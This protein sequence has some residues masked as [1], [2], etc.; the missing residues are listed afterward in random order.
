MCIRDRLTG[1][2]FKAT[3][4]T[5]RE[6]FHSYW[7]MDGK[8]KYTLKKNIYDL[9]LSEGLF[10]TGD[11]TIDS[12][13]MIGNYQCVVELEGQKFVSSRALFSDLNS[14]FSLLEC[15]LSD[16]KALILT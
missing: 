8:R 14:E 13:H 15:L 9:E 16:Y 11:L 7:L 10:K 1:C 3:R 2:T 12:P 5:N 4:E 6:R